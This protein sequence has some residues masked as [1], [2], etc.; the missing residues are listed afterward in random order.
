ML[1]SIM[2][3]CFQV[4]GVCIEYCVAA[5]SYELLFSDLFQMFKAIR[6]DH[7]FLE[8]MEPYLLNRELSVLPQHILN[9]F[10][11][12]YVR[13]IKFAALERCIFYLDLANNDVTDLIACLTNNGLYSGLLYVKAYK[14]GD[15]AEAFKSVFE[16]MMNPKLAGSGSSRKKTSNSGT[17]GFPSLDQA[18]VGYKLL[19]FCKYV[20]E[21]KIFP[22]GDVQTSPVQ[23]LAGLSAH[24]LSQP[25]VNQFPILMPL[26]RVD[27]SGLVYVL[28]LLLGRL[29][30]APTVMLVNPVAVGDLYSAFYAFVCSADATLNSADQLQR[31]FFNYALERLVSLSYQLSSSLLQ[32]IVAYCSSQLKSRKEAEEM[33]FSLAAKQSK[34]PEVCRYL[35]EVLVR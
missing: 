10:V 6:Q 1:G 17:D 13:T 9:A 18:H 27:S 7:V 8:E 15:Y 28:T 31:L 14:F 33:M 2:D 19:L 32:G 26:A 12:S 30:T 34:F 5:G 16:C 23:Q 22:R 20:S 3:A 35:R 29:A 21:N 11:D 4:S 24:L 25:G